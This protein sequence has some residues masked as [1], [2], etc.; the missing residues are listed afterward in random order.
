MA[1]PSQMPRTARQAS[2]RSQHPRRGGSIGALVVSGVVVAVALGGW[3]WFWRDNDA[4]KAAKAGEPPAQAILATDEPVNL[5]VDDSRT[6]APARRD[7]NA[8]ASPTIPTSSGPTETKPNPATPPTTTPSTTPT[9]TPTTNPTSIPSTTAVPTTSTPGT[10]A[11]VTPAPVEPQPNPN[12]TPESLTSP[13]SAAAQT[14]ASDPVIQRYFATAESST[15]AGRL[16]EARAA[17]NRAMHDPRATDAEIAQARTKITA[18]NETLVFSPTVTPA[19]PLVETYAIQPGDRLITIV[20]GHDLKV[21]W[22]FVQRVNKMSDPGRLRVGQKLKLVRGPF[23]AVVDK[24]DYRLDLYSD[25]TDADGN[26]LYIR[27]FRVGLGEAGSTPLGKWVVR[28]SSKLV[29]PHW[30]NP[31]TGE[32]FHADDPKNPI[33]EFW[34]G[35]TGVESSTEVLSGYGIHGTIEPD[36]IGKDASMGCVRLLADDIAM[37]YEMLSEQY[38]T[39]E[40]RP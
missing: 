34:L 35:L 8:L 2:F 1:L 31:R 32:K 17:L 15:S 26:R 16:P 25:A 21:D 22:R 14:M 33:G 4:P 36:S 12:A 13:R 9:T 40:I 11:P 18:I 5:A 20:R 39:V 10:A 28:S 29:N 38:S 24:S 27:S 23:H 37:V 30:V 7:W 19:D 3:W 6:P